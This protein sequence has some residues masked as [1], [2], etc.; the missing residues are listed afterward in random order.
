MAD[1]RNDPVAMWQNIIGEMEK[2]FNAFAK[3]ALAPPQF[4]KVVD[5]P[6]RGSADAPNQLGDLMENYLVSMNLPS[7]AQV[8]SLAERLQ[9]IEEQLSEIKALLHQAPRVPGPAKARPAAPTRLR[10]RRPPA[11]GGEQK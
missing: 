10:P 9:S 5:S 4:G 3:R 1:K 8:E 6:G 7:R 11:P 2:G